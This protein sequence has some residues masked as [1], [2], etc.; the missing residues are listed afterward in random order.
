MAITQQLLFGCLQWSCQQIG[1]T[2]RQMYKERCRDIYINKQELNNSLP[3]SSFFHSGTFLPSSSP[4][5]LVCQLWSSKA[6]LN[7]DRQGLSSGLGTFLSVNVFLNNHIMFPQQRFCQF[8]W[9]LVLSSFSW[10]LVSDSSPKLSMK[11]TYPNQTVVSTIAQL[12]CSK[13]KK[14]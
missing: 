8:C 3:C 6:L 4:F 1:F 12:L 13:T 11:V 10:V 7:P 2:K 14:N 5:N 9:C